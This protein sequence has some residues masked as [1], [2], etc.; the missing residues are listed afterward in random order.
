M[1]HS[2]A[3]VS[4]ALTLVACGSGAPPAATAPHPLAPPIAAPSPAVPASV[5]KLADGAVLFDDLGSHH[6]AVTA[7]AE[8]Q[9]WFD[10][11]LRLAYGFNHDEAARSFAKGATVDPTCAMCFW[12]AA[13]TLGPNYNMPMMPTAAQAAW[14]ALQRARELAVR[15]TPV[16]QALI[17]ALGKRYKGP[18]PLEPDAMKPFN[19]AYAVA[20]KAVATQFASDDDAMVLAAEAGMDVHPWKL[21]SLDGKAAEGTDWIVTTLET[22]LARSANHPGANHYY[23]HAVEASPHPEKAVP[24]AERL[25]GL[26]PGAGHVVHMPAHIFQR[27]GRYAD[28]SRTNEQAVVAD[29][30]YMQKVTAPGMYPM[31]LAHNYGFLSFSASM[32]GRSKTSLDA[33]RASAKALPAGMIDLMPGMDFFVSEPILAMVR[34]GAWDALLA[35]PKP[36]AKYPVLTA[37]WLHGHGLALAAKG[38]RDEA[39]ADLTALQAMAQKAPEIDVGLSPAKIVFALAAKILEARLATLEKKP[40]ALALWT[41]ATR[42]AD[43]LSY[44][45]PDDWFYSVRTF[46]GAALLGAGKA[47]EAEAVYREDLRRKPNNGWSLFGLWKS[48]DAQKK[49]K[50]SA[51]A[52]AEFDKAWASA[53]VQLTSSAF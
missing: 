32:E 51:A 31:Y 37:F 5:A 1:N 2:I 4:A 44:S 13:L 22:V 45:E 12:G 20:M 16:E 52:K 3:L 27:V 34:F 50:E 42:L 40:D 6:R 47:K 9:P 35:E 36:D 17:G 39:H 43:T 14:D 8:A 10:Q 53:D 38:K 48:L 30:K 7:S 18:E 15:G 24:S 21:W 26:M 11:G 33:A 25:A 49:G 28:A 41:E 29:Q 23:I 19:A 46:E